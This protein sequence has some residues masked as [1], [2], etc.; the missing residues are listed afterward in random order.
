RF[1]VIVTFGL[2]FFARAQKLQHLPQRNMPPS[3][4]RW[5]AFS[6]KRMNGTFTRIYLSYVDE[7]GKAY[8]PL[9][10]PQKDPVFYDF[11]LKTYS[12]PELVTE[13]VRVKRED[14]TQAVYGSRGIPAKMPITMA[15]PKA[16]SMPGYTE[17]LLEGE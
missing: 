9:L 1:D 12:V 3:N 6:S 2:G 4:S 5:I 16:G 11:C 10:L 14:L 17:P 15:T 8:K 13:P 7:A